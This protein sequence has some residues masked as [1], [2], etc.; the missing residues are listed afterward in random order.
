MTPAVAAIGFPVALIARTIFI[1]G[2]ASSMA[3][4]EEEGGGVN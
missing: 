4:E 1:N 3:E 2:F